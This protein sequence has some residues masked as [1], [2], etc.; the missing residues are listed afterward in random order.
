MATSFWY[1]YSKFQFQ[2]NSVIM[3]TILI[4]IVHIKGM[5]VQFSS[6]ILKMLTNLVLSILIGIDENQKV[7]RFF[8]N[9]NGKN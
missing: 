9:V 3:A 4:I 6:V 1:L 2:L 7:L 8:M 5:W